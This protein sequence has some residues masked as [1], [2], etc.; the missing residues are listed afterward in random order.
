MA[1]LR[2]RQRGGVTEVY[3]HPWVVRLVHAVNALCLLVLLCSGLQILN[4][5]PAFYWGEIS[6]FDTPL[7]AI[8]NVQ[9]ADGALRGRL[10]ILGAAFDTT[11]V[12]GVSPAADG[13]VEARA[14]PAWLTLPPY[15]DLGAGR[16]WHFA[17]A[18]LLVANGAI[19]LIH[20]FASGRIRLQLLPTRADLAG[21]GRSVVDHLRLRFDHGAAYNVLQK[22]T[23]LVV[24]F[25]LLPAMLLTGLVMSPAVY[26]W[27]PWLGDLFGGRQSA[28][29]IHFLS[30]SGLVL[31][32][33]VHLAMVV[34]AGPINELKS[35]I[36]GWYALKTR[37]ETK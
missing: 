22:L 7:A 36:T 27:A 12:L 28:R 8:D 35:I 3:R 33:V 4:A 1:G 10:R 30:A 6:H 29:T 11:G 23:Y 37:R 15:P 16:A 19:Y 18:W 26:A 14:F 13:G 5:H 34:A 17:F 20:G 25:G 31:F 32:V 21:F 24:I 2:E 9:A